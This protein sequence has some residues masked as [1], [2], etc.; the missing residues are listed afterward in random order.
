MLKLNI[1]KKSYD[2]YPFI[3][4]LQLE[5]NAGDFICIRGRSGSGKSTLMN[6]FNLLDNDYQGQ[7]FFHDIDLRSLKDHEKAEFRK[8]HFGIIFQEFNLIPK[9]DVYQNIEFA[10]KLVGYTGDHES[11]ILEVLEMVGLKGF[12]HR[13][14]NEL[15]GGQQQRV[16]IA[17]ALS[18]EPD[19]IFADEPTGNLDSA[20]SKE[21]IDVLTELN[22]SGITIILI[23]HNEKMELYANRT[24]TIFRGKIE[25][26]ESIFDIENRDVKRKESINFSLKNITQFAYSNLFRH[27]IKYIVSN[28]ILIATIVIAAFYLAGINS[29]VS[30]AVNDITKNNFAISILKDYSNYEQ[31]YNDDYNDVLDDVASLFNSSTIETTKNAMSQV[32]R[33]NGIDFSELSY[34]FIT[35]KDYSTDSLNYYLEAGSDPI[36]DYDVVVDEVFIKTFLN[37]DYNISTSDPNEYIN[38][39]VLVVLNQNKEEVSYTFHITGIDNSY[40]LDYD[41]GAQPTIFVSPS[42]LELLSND[43]I[44]DTTSYIY[45]PSSSYNYDDIEEILMDN[46][47]VEGH[48]GGGSEEDENASKMNEYSINYPTGYI[49]NFK[50]VFILTVIAFIAVTSSISGAALVNV[51]NRREKELGIFYS[52]GLDKRDIFKTLSI[53][54]AIN[55]IIV[56]FA[57]VVLI[58]ISIGYLYTTEVFLKPAI[59]FNAKDYV[60]ILILLVF[61]TSLSLIIS[62]LK[63]RNQDPIKI[64]KG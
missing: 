52:L 31:E 11:R 28:I 44:V 56:Y 47:Y 21:I 32:Y 49:Y 36:N 4:D 53:E 64:I 33:I 62:Y 40:A 13:Q 57:M 6:I 58:N 39:D 9:M 35:F 34:L 38:K 1:E 19:I 22:Q 48:D 41:R 29:Y 50:T 8:N 15:S 25:K 60:A 54:F 46:G 2:D 3:E 45:A 43:I 10:L 61:I 20:T 42:T 63:I 51:I 17:R 24:I 16:S 5:I 59:I 23:T 7:Y 18:V 55:T 27:K 30:F 26:D 14:I 37:S 12:E